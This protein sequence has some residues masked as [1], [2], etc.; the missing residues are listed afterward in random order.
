VSLKLLDE[1]SLPGDHAK[2]NED[3]FACLDRAALV[4]DGATPLGPPLL[5]GPS[6][7]AWIA[8]FGARR[9]STYLK[10]GDP[11]DDALKHALEDTEKSFAGLARAPIREKWQMPCASM[12]LIYDPIRTSQARE[13]ATALGSLGREACPASSADARGGRGSQSR[14]IQFFWY[15]DCAALIE[16]DGKVEI[17]GEAIKKRKA[18]AARAERTAREKNLASAL[19]ANRPEIEPLLR[20]TRNRINSGGN[21]LFSPDPRAAKHVSRQTL[22]IQEGARMLLASDGFLALVSD[23]DAYDVPGLIRAAAGK[24]LTR[25]GEELRAIEMDDAQGGR[26]FRFKPSDDATALFLQLI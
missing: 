3:S 8:Q 7:A 1:L 9:L 21:W 4:L 5:P 17:V 19:G 10:D 12:M 20:A 2:P 16:Q 18:E 23:Y 24:G 14:S 22:A 25:L 6:D 26:F 11:P 13:P 15:G